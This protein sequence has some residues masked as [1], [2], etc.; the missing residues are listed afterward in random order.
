MPTILSESPSQTGN[1]F[2]SKDD[3]FK[4]VY[5]DAIRDEK[6]AIMNTPA[7]IGHQSGK[8]EVAI[9]C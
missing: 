4:I 1:L 5:F 2:K 7:R 9:S 6:G 8:I 3:K